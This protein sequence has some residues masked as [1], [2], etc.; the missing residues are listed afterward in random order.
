MIR[1]LLIAGAMFAA[2]VTPALAQ[3]AVV[4]GLDKVTGH[5][6]DYTLTLGRPA[7]VGS[8]DDAERL[9][10][11]AATLRRQHFGERSLEYALSLGALG[12]LWYGEGRLQESADALRQAYELHRASPPDVHRDVALAANDCAAAERALGNVARARELHG[13]ALAL[14]RLAG[15]PL[16]I[17][18]SLNNL[19]NSEP[20]L[21]LARAQL[22]EALALRRDVLGDDDPL[23]IQSRTNLATLLMRLGAW[24]EARPLLVDAVERSRRLA[25]LGS[26]YLAVAL[27]LLAMT[28]LQLGDAEAAETAIGEALALDRQ[29]LG[30]DHVRLAA[31]LEIHARIAE[32]R[33]RWEDAAE[34]WREVLR[35]RRDML[36]PGHR[37]LALTR[38]SLGSA[39]VRAGDVA[40]G[41]VELRGASEA[42]AGD[43]VAAVDRIDAAVCLA[44][45]EE[46][47][48]NLEVAERL[49]R[50]A[51]QHS[52]TVAGAPR[53]DAVA[54][55]LHEFLRRRGR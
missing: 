9:L 21:T 7:R 19:A 48:G 44:L 29:R 6:R 51:L 3:R 43:D 16:Q 33:G 26:E 8:L 39:L 24:Q 23:T 41:L 45:G 28:E 54:A 55:R 49:L 17:A 32:R 52:A 40:S 20:D 11:E 13:E 42:L 35:L 15:E 27:R 46:A 25:S 2:S 37:L 47:A 50:D 34:A 12:Q 14:R 30:D 4:R 38:C 53:A 5:A 1:T 10:E 31:P 22:E 18:E 36:P